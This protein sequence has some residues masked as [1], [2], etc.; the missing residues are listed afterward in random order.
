MGGA[1]GGNYALRGA[2][3]KSLIHRALL[4]V[5]SQIARMKKQVTQM[6]KKLIFENLRNLRLVNESTG[7]KLTDLIFSK[8][9]HS[10]FRSHL[11][12]RFE[13]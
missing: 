6:K 3:S 2:T 10:H 5:D 7:R 9:S 13:I 12:L 1:G 8:L 4:T 11:G